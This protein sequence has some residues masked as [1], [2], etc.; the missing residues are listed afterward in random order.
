MEL[1][2]HG[3]AVQCADVQ[4]I[5]DGARLGVPHW[6]QAGGD[7]TAP[8]PD[9]EYGSRLVLMACILVAPLVIAGYVG[10]TVLLFLPLLGLRRMLSRRPAPAVVG[11][12]APLYSGVGN[13]WDAATRRA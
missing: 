2:D 10:L 9:G 4:V 6:W 8:R 13:L 12:D 3:E 1:Q 5:R 7:V 11:W